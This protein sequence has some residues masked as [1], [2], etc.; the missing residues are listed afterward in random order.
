M[1]ACLRRGGVRFPVDFHCAGCLGVKRP[2]WIY[3]A[4][5]QIAASAGICG[6]ADADAGNG[7]KDFREVDEE[8]ERPV[9]A[10]RRI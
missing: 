1:R 6:S 4:G 2:G 9:A 5:G 8:K 3:Y 7:G 10:S